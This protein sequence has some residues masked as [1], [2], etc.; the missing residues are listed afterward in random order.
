MLATGQIIPTGGVA[1]LNVSGIA[2]GPL[3]TSRQIGSGAFVEI[4]SNPYPGAI[5]VVVDPGVGL[6]G[7]LPSNQGAI[8]YQLQD[9][10]GSLTISGLIPTV[11]LAATPDFL[12]ETVLRAF[13]AAVPAL[14]VPPGYQPASVLLEMPRTGFPTLPFVFFTPTTLEQSQTQIGQDVPSALRLPGNTQLATV[15]VQVRRMWQLSI[16][17]LTAGERDFYRDSCLGVFQSLLGSVFLP[18]SQDMRHNFSA[19]SGQEAGGQFDPGLY[20]CDLLLSVE[21]M[22]N[23]GLVPQY[24]TILA[25]SGNVTGWAGASGTASTS[26]TIAAIV[27]S[28]SG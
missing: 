10:S 26:G 6:P 21:G 4:D 13:Q 20:R 22:F 17:A 5:C 23:V 16:L 18:L 12:D 25:I 2:G 3:V 19:H 9:A 1:I 27:V 28:A 11:S 8:S 24:G 7:P 14:V 15:S